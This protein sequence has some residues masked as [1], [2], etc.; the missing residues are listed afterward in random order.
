M[1][2]WHRRST[3]TDSGAR[4]KRFRGKRKHELGRTPTET[5]MGE[6]KRK[7]IVSKGY[8][9]KAPV[10]RVTMVNV[11]DPKKNQ[12]FRVEIQDVETNPASMDYQRRKVITRG[13]IIKTAK[14]N[15]MV[16]SRPGQDGILNAVL[17]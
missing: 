8:N 5:V 6:T 16:T 13:T 9:R 15:A 7:K 10:L 14:G 11:T 2:V 12:T 3:R 17:I 4:L 1:G